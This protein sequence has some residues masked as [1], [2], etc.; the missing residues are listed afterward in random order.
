[1]RKPASQTARGV[2]R[3]ANTRR[4]AFCFSAISPNPDLGEPKGEQAPVPAT[5]TTGGTLGHAQQANQP[6][7]FVTPAS[8]T[9]TRGIQPNQQATTP[10]WGYQTTPDG[11]I[12]ATPP[13]TRE[14]DWGPPA[15][16]GGPQDDS[17]KDMT[18]A[19]EAF[20]SELRLTA[21]LLDTRD[22]QAPFAQYIAPGESPGEAKGRR[23]LMRQ[24]S[25]VVQF[26]NR[27]PSFLRNNPRAITQST[28]SAPI[29]MHPYPRPLYLPD[30]DYGEYLDDDVCL[31]YYQG[32]EDLT[33]M[34]PPPPDDNG[35]D[36]T[37]STQTAQTSAVKRLQPHTEK[38][39]ATHKQY[40]AALQASTPSTQAA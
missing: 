31:D 2:A 21:E 5:Q 26:V 1:M 35:D 32:N 38:V 16:H 6:P 18:E 15:T 20:M 11:T 17:G 27:M 39:L 37:V 4:Q 25:S 24:F 3:K 7:I 40:L 22:S 8:R 19:D 30:N 12:L 34:L 14:R 29:T 28:R 36:S 33:A 13:P 23:A 10:Q 9:S